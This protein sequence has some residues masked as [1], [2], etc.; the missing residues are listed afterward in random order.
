MSSNILMS[1]LTKFSKHLCKFKLR[2]MRLRNIYFEKLR[3]GI[4]TEVLPN[5]Q[6]D[7]CCDKFIEKICISS[8]YQEINRRPLSFVNC[9]HQLKTSEKV[10]AKVVRIKNWNSC[11]ERYFWCFSDFIKDEFVVLL[12]RSLSK[13][14]W[15]I[16]ITMNI[17]LAAGFKIALLIILLLLKNKKPL[18]VLYDWLNFQI[19]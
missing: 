18:G 13:E 5:V 19:S 2:S 10:I 12:L 17:D 16:D 11:F 7:L 3:D 6:D 8:L 15:L 1:A 14:M 9:L 4:N